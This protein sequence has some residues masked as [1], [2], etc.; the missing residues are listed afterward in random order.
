MSARVQVGEQTATV[1]AGVWRSRDPRFASLCESVAWTD[2]LSYEPDPD[3]AA[4]ERVAAALN[5]RVIAYSKPE[6]T[7][8]GRVYQQPL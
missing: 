5:G 7:V 8:K 2:S 6:R 4:A 1:E 3:R